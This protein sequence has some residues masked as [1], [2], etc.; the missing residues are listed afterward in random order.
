M[1]FKSNLTYA[2][3]KI[4]RKN[5]IK[6]N[7]KLTIELPHVDINILVPTLQYQQTCLQCA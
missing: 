5:I 1:L 2:F 7:I 6:I 3:R 4:F